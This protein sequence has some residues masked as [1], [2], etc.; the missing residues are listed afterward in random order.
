MPYLS[1]EQ[2]DVSKCH[3]SLQR[4]QLIV[5][6][7]CY[8]E[9]FKFFKLRKEREKIG[10]KKGNLLDLSAPESKVFS[11]VCQLQ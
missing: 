9:E 2:C 10:K 7:C 3:T 8:S 1:G 11:V 4:I 5:Y 6:I